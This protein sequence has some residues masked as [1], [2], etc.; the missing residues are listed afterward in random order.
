MPFLRRHGVERLDALVLSHAHAD[1]LGGASSVL[2]R[3]PAGE[4][5]DPALQT[6]DPLYAGFLAQLDELDEPWVRGAQGGRLH[7]STASVSGSCT[8]TRPGRSGARI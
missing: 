8:R 5:I 4:V 6:P 3:I 1:H 2:E 7:R